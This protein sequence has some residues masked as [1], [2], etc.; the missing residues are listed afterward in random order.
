MA[1]TPIHAQVSKAYAQV[2][3]K[4]AQGRRDGCCGGSVTA[5]AGYGHETAAYQGV[6]GLS[7]GCGNPLALAG[8]Q[9]GQTVLNLGSGAVFWRAKT[10]PVSKAASP[11]CAWWAA[12]HNLH[13]IAMRLWRNHGKACRTLRCPGG[14]RPPAAGPAAAPGWWK[15]GARANGC[16][17]VWPL[18]PHPPRGEVAPV[19]R[20]S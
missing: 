14:R 19:H 6:S 4:A 13:R 20:T 18:Q 1:L 9:A 2:L 7:F 3:D 5:L 8:V 12:R 10:W 15:V 11:A 17:T 16:I